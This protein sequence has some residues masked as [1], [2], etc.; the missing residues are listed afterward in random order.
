MID[1]KAWDN[2]FAAFEETDDPA[3]RGRE[4]VRTDAAGAKAPAGNNAGSAGPVPAPKPFFKTAAA[5]EEKQSTWNAAGLILDSRE[6]DIDEEDLLCYQI[7]REYTEVAGDGSMDAM[8]RGKQQPESYWDAAGDLTGNMPGTD[9]R[10]YLEI[11]KELTGSSMTDETRQKIL[12]Q[13]NGTGSADSSMKAFYAAFSLLQDSPSRDRIADVIDGIDRMG[14][15]ADDGLYLL[16][17]AIEEALE[18]QNMRNART[19]RHYQDKQNKYD[20]QQSQAQTEFDKAKRRTDR[21]R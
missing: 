12:L 17:T 9:E 7:R 4:S 14:E 11:A 1:K 19:D 8:L 5:R 2:I 16:R 13:K 15:R 20:R 18:L 6:E 3:S 10:R 21:W